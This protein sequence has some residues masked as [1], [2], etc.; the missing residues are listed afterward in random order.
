MY[1]FLIQ[2][3]KR[4][5]KETLP[6]IEQLNEVDV[7]SVPFPEGREMGEVVLHMVR[8]LEF[9][10][11]GI[12]TNQWEF[13]QY[14]V[15]EYDSAEAI[16]ELARNVFKHVEVYTSLVSATDMERKVKSFDTEATIAELILEMIEH[17]VHHRGQLTM[18]LRFWGVAPIP[19]KYIV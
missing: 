13:L 16:I 7:F 12:A 19:I 8:S 3:V 10:M 1:K 4:H 15:E 17:S 2:A 6:I 9:Y 14:S 11:K 5:L 18:Y